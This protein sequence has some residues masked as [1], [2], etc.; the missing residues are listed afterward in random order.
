[1]SVSEQNT[2]EIKL[3]PTTGINL[4]KVDPREHR[5]TPDE[6]FVVLHGR[7][8]NT[9]QDYLI[10]Y[11]RRNQPLEGLEMFNATDFK[12]VGAY[13]I[14]KETYASLS[15]GKQTK[16]N[17]MELVGVPACPCCGNQL[18]AVVC[19]C[20]N[21]FCVGES[22]TNECPWCGMRGTLGKGDPTG[23]DITRGLG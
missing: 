19:E 11:A 15:A 9:K 1:M 13:P 20:G 18:G 12:L 2:D 6:N 16:I 14:D 22:N 8:Q 4:E 21:I 7:C 3:A 10:K 5:D 23:M 17:T